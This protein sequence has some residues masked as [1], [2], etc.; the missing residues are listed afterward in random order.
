MKTVYIET[1]NGVKVVKKGA[2][3]VVELG[4]N[5]TLTDYVELLFSVVGGDVAIYKEAE[6]AFWANK[7][8]VDTASAWDW[9]SAML[10]RFDGEDIS[11][12]WKE[13]EWFQ[14]QMN[15]AFD[16][17]DWRD[18]DDW[19]NLEPSCENFGDW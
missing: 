19:K 14:E 3:V 11:E 15:G 16:V 17:D 12:V 5:F 9:R 8:L 6:N 2:N 10:M 13:A 7:C 18:I 1:S 4:E